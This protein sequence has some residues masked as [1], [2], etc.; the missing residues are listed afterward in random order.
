MFIIFWV[1]NEYI[2]TLLTF[3]AVPIFAA[4]LVISLIADK[5][6]NSKVGKSYYVLIGGLAFIPMVIF[7][8]I[9]LTNGGTSFDW[10]K[11]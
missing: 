9:F 2:A 5:I 4:I 8:V 3:V 1:T 11:Q 10:I 7:F 6:E